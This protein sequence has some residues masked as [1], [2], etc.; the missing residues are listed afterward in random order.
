MEFQP[1]PIAFATFLQCDRRNA[2]HLLHMIWNFELRYGYFF[3]FKLVIYIKKFVFCKSNYYRKYLLYS[4][5]WLKTR[6]VTRFP[7][8]CSTRDF[9]CKITLKLNFLLKG[10]A[11]HAVKMSQALRKSP[12][13]ERVAP[14]MNSLILTSKIS[15]FFCMPLKDTKNCIQTSWNALILLRI[16]PRINHFPLLITS[17]GFCKQCIYII[18]YKWVKGDFLRAK[19]RCEYIPLKI[20]CHHHNR[21]NSA[22]TV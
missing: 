22:I 13:S 11:C 15:F 7:S 1:L 12:S 4:E 2:T 19:L 18:T 16:R 5:V 9:C 20:A 14:F 21:N 6:Q 8:I 3:I 10:M 17:W